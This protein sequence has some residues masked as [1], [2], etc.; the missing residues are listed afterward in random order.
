MIEIERSILGSGADQEQASGQ[1]RVSQ[2][3]PHR[4]IFQWGQLERS[5]Y[6]KGLG[7][8]YCFCYRAGPKQ[9]TQQEENSIRGLAPEGQ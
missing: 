3:S 1:P 9:I 8:D 7:G 4:D 6:E 5:Y 2:E